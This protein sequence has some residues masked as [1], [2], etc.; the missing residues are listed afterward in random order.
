MPFD[1]MPRSLRGCRLATITTL[2]SDQLLRLVGLGDA[3]H[4]GARL[5]LADIDFQ[6]QQLVGAFDAL[7]GEHQAHAQIDLEEIVDGDLRRGSF[8]GLRPASGFLPSSMAC[9]RRD[10]LFELAHLVDGVLQLDAREDAG[11]LA[12]LLARLASRPSASVVEAAPIRCGSVMP[13]CAQIFGVDS[14]ST[15]ES[16]AVTM[17]SASAAV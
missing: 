11:D 14:G 7:G 3:G 2:R 5:R 1:S 13:S 10:L 15:G 6:V 9:S 4:D 16:S 8:G 17:R 12:D